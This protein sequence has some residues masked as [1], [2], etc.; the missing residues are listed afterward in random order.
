VIRQT[1]RK[2][3]AR[4]ISAQATRQGKRATLTIDAADE[5]GQFLNDA[6]VEVTV[7][8]PQL[9]QEKILMKQAAPGRYATDFA[10][11]TPGAYHMEIA[12]KQNG[13]IVYR[14]SRGM[15]VGYSDE[16]RIR[17]ANEALLRA[18]ADASGGTFSPYPATLFAAD[19]RTAS[20]PTPLCTW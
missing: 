2:S 15:T 17:P 5:L 6:E 1:M 11:D 18:V 4:G 7:I 3:D 16:L 12:L 9:K 10:A 13:E 20:R 19:E 8:N 14:Q